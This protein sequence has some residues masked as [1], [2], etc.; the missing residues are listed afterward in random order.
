M[1]NLKGHASLVVGASRGI[2]RAVAEYLIRQGARV[3]FTYHSTADAAKELNKLAS[4]HKTEALAIQADARDIDSLRQ[5]LAEA[6]E[7]FGG[8][9]S[10]IFVTAG[11]II[12]KPTAELSLEEYDGM[13]DVVRGTYFTLQKSL[14]YLNKNGSIVCF[15]TGGTK[16]AMPTQGAYTGAK[17]AIERFCLSLSKEGGEMG[18]RVNLVSPGVT[19]TDGLTISNQMIGQ[20][21][22]QTPLGRLG[23]PGDIAPVV[24][25]L[26]SDEARW[27]NGQ[28]IGVNGGIL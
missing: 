22:E 7:A 2:G 5:M 23:E 6:S 16:M 15:S 24:A 18:I 27:I 11:N 17:A 13:F 10:L 19:K 21:K 26:V 9:D 3:A 1:N 4:K 28:I 20:L 12:S 14:Q 25:F 8:L